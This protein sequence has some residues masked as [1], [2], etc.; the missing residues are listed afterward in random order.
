MTISNAVQLYGARYRTRK[1]VGKGKRQSKLKPA[2][3]SVKVDNS[4]ESASRFTGFRPSVSTMINLVTSINPKAVGFP[5]FFDGAFPA[6]A[7]QLVV[8]EF[9]DAY[10]LSRLDCSVSDHAQRAHLRNM[11]TGTLWTQF[12]HMGHWSVPFID[13]MKEREVA[14]PDGLEEK[15]GGPG[16]NPDHPVFSD[17]IVDKRYHELCLLEQFAVSRM[18]EPVFEM[19][20]AGY[21]KDLETP[22]LINTNCVNPYSLFTVIEYACYNQDINVVRWLVQ[23]RGATVTGGC[24]HLVF[25]GLS[26]ATEDDLLELIQ[27]LVEECGADVDYRDEYHDGAL[28]NAA[29]SGYLSIV[30]YLVEEA[31]SDVS[32]RDYKFEDE[33]DEDED[34]SGWNGWNALDAACI[35]PH[36]HVLEYLVQQCKVKVLE[37]N[38]YGV[39]A[40]DDFRD[41]RSQS[42]YTEL[43]GKE[44]ED[45]VREA[46]KVLKLLEQKA[47]EE[48]SM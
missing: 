42:W 8:R 5:L 3:T 23:E 32:L 38:F 12:R 30:R 10:D 2:V 7:Y 48:R 43:E 39:T 6:I 19:L 35:R 9:L 13:W 4:E 34:A 11:M 47:R 18:K 24:L 16:F 17:G 28:A 41:F 37:E 36:F 27:Y 22:M 45:K 26:G 33:D 29:Y 1:V 14:L 21:P 40:L 31:G 20:K 25:F 46:Q 44:R 15:L